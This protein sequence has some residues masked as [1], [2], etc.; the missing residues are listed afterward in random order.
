MRTTLPFVLCS[1]LAKNLLVKGT[2]NPNNKL[3]YN[4]FTYFTSFNHENISCFCITATW[5]L[6]FFNPSSSPLLLASYLNPLYFI[7]KPFLLN[8][9]IYS[10]PSTL[11]WR[12]LYRSYILLC[13]FACSSWHLLL[14]PN[15]TQKGYKKLNVSQANLYSFPFAREGNE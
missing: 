5:T 3:W 13:S 10:A 8:N 12:S 9:S 7:Q 2:I 6:Q 15:K 1:V 14:F 11:V 4:Y